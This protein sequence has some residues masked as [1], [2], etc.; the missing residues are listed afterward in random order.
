MLLATQLQCSLEQ[1]TLIQHWT[2]TLPW[3]L[4]CSQKIQFLA[5]TTNSKYL[6]VRSCASRGWRVLVLADGEEGF[7]LINGKAVARAGSLAWDTR[8][9]GCW[10]CCPPTDTSDEP[11]LERLRCFSWLYCNSVSSTHLLQ[12]RRKLY[13]DHT[14]PANCWLFPGCKSVRLSVQS[15]NRKKGRL[16][17]LLSGTVKPT[18]E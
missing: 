3:K 2:P 9:G 12:S 16:V 18:D 11:L 14:L 6:L 17:T 15:S 4:S 1:Q 5:N 8:G 7:V 10:R 13:S